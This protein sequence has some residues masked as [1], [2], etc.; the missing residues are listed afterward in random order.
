M[1]IICFLLVLF[2]YIFWYS[3][4]RPSASN[5]LFGKK[6]WANLQ[7][8]D[9]SN[10]VLLMHLS[11]GDIYSFNG[12]DILISSDSQ[13]KILLNSY[14]SPY[15]KII[16]NIQYCNLSNDDIKKIKRNTK[17]TKTV[18]EIIYASRRSHAPSR[19]NAYSNP[20]TH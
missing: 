5:S 4:L 19:G 20:K 2:L 9:S 3:E 13:C 6:E 11:K 17:V 18:L 7:S 16:G 1:K 12:S 8:L 15:V 14:F 10:G